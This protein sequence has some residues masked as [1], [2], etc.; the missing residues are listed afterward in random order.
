[1]IGQ[2]VSPAFKQYFKRCQPGF[3]LLAVVLAGMLRVSLGVLVQVH[4]RLER[5]VVTGDQRLGLLR[6]R[7]IRP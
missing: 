3:G 4:L 7:R 5:G 6:R 2:Q 1:M